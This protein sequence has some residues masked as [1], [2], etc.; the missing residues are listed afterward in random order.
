MNI[1]IAGAT[2]ALA[3]LALSVRLAAPAAPFTCKEMQS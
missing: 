1:G 2:V 3:I